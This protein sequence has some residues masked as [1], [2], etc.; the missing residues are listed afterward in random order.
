MKALSCKVELADGSLVSLGHAVQLDLQLG[1]FRRK[2]LRCYVLPAASVH[3][4]FLGE[5][6]LLEHEVVLE[7]EA[8]QGVVA[9]I[10]HG[11]RTVQAD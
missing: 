3:D 10:M 5:S 11:M 9:H 1:A 7:Y 4:V 8:E 2:D 6:W